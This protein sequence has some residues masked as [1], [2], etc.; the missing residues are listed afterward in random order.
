MTLQS[1]QF[2]EHFSGHTKN[3]PNHGLRCKEQTIGAQFKE[4][5]G[6]HAKNED[7]FGDLQQRPL[8]DSM[9]RS[10]E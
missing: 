1:T 7:V 4:H 8:D 10:L 9:A 2:K 3:I 6:S 5:F